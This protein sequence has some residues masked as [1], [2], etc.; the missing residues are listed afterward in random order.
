MRLQRGVDYPYT[1]VRWGYEASER[2]GSL[3]AGPHQAPRR[4]HSMG[5]FPA[6]SIACHLA[7]DVIARRPGLDPR[8]AHV[9]Q[10][11]RHKPI[12]QRNYIDQRGE[13]MPEILL[14]LD[15][16]QIE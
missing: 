1:L 11:F 6:S 3:S 5:W 2:A 16:H 14:K 7:I 4:H 15:L 8:V 10:H 13:D 9:K 12:E